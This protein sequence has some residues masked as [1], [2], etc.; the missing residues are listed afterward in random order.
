MEEKFV[1]ALTPEEKIRSMEDASK[2]IIR[3]LHVYEKSLEDV[4]YNY[5]AYVYAVIIF[6]S[7]CNDLVDYDLTEVIVQ[8]HS[9]LSNDFDKRQIRKIVLECRNIV[10]SLLKN[11]R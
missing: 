10:E 7:S 6:I 4:N 9:L 8:L 1:V 3:I 11:L 5:R 2:K